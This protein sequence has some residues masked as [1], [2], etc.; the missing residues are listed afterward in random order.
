[1]NLEKLIEWIK[2]LTK[3]AP[4]AI[5]IA[6]IVIATIITVLVTVLNLTSCSTYIKVQEAEVSS[7]ILKSLE[8]PNKPE[9]WEQ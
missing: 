3:S 8:T 6:L 7:S 1:M 4:K 9:P 5:K 2:E